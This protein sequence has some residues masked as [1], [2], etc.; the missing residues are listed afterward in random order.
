MRAYTEFRRG[1]EDGEAL[2]AEAEQRVVRSLRADAAPAVEDRDMA[3]TAWTFERRR[4]VVLHTLRPLAAAGCVVVAVLPFAVKAWRG[5]MD[6][7]D[8]LAPFVAP[9]WPLAGVALA[10][11]AA[12]I[13][14]S[15]HGSEFRVRQT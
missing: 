5:G 2:P 13:L 10:L 11:I 1:L 9:G 4:L 6:A 7:G 8:A 14:G 3:A 12:G 15:L